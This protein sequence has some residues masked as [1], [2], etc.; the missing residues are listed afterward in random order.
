MSHKYLNPSAKL[1]YALQWVDENGKLRDRVVDDMNLM[2]ETFALPV[3]GKKLHV[4]FDLLTDEDEQRGKVSINEL[5]KRRNAKL[6]KKKMS[7][8]Q[9]ELI[10]RDNRVN[11][12]VKLYNVDS[13]RGTGSGY[14]IGTSVN[15]QGLA[16][17]TK[18]YGQVLTD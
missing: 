4:P 14:E 7:A 2:G 16:T 1:P 17:M 15:L 5:V 9:K 10:A 3:V 12:L 6:G 13:S 18:R 8:H 11:E